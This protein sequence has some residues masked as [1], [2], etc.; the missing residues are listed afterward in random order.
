MIV[1]LTRKDTAV[2]L[3]SRTIAFFLLAFALQAG[4]S[5]AKQDDGWLEHLSGP[6]PFIRFPS[7]DIRVVCF[8]RVAND[9]YVVGLAPWGRGSTAE[10]AVR[11][12]RASTTGGAA[13]A[14]EQCSKDENVRG[15]IAVAYGHYTGVE[16]NLFANNL[17]DDVFKVKAESAS[18]RFMGRTLGDAVDIGF[19]ANIFWFHGKAF[20]TFTRFSLEPARISV[21]P[22]VAINNSA[23]SR[24]FHVTVAP[25]I[26]FGHMDQD[27]FCNT[28]A[29]TVVP[30]QFSSRFETLW[31][32]TFEVDI[33]TL[34]KGN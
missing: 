14:K 11:P 25:T 4:V 12:Y 16:N 23:R 20:E 5:D 13:T 28:S 7:L 27:D 22:F 26:F 19:G 1:S 33:L 31:A 10:F 2:K 32:T 8:T 15:F 18:I 9:N 6:G 29:C 17:T 24:A 30:R 34:I 21:A 3:A